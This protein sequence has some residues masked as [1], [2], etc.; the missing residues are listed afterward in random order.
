MANEIIHETNPAFYEPFLDDD[1][2]IMLCIGSYGSG[3]SFEMFH[4]VALKAITER[5]RICVIR[6]EY[7]RHKDSTFEDLSDAFESFGVIDQFDF[8]KSPLKIQH[9]SDRNRSRNKYSEIIFKD[10]SDQKKIKGIKNIDYM[11]VEEA[12]EIDYDILKELMGRLRTDSVRTHMLMMTNPGL[13][14]DSVDRIIKEW[15]INLEEL[16]EKKLLTKVISVDVPGKGKRDIKIKIHHST[17][18]DNLFNSAQFIQTIENYTDPDMIQIARLGRYGITEGKVFK[19]LEKMDNVWDWIKSVSGKTHHF[20]WYNGLDF[21]YSVSF[22]CLVKMA[23][24]RDSRTLYIY[25]GVYEKGLNTDT[26]IERLKNS[27]IRGEKLI[28]DNAEPR[29]IDDLNQAGLWVESAK[30]GQGSV[31]YGL[32]TLK[33]FRKI[34]I[35]SSLDKVWND[36][37]GLSRVKEKDGN[38]SEKR[39]NIDPH[40]LTGDTLVDTIYGAKPIKDLVG[41]EGFLA[42]YDVENKESTVS[43]YYDCKK[44]GTN[45]KIYKITT[46]DG[47]IIKATDYHPIL[48]E[49]GYVQVKNLLPT[50]RIIDIKECL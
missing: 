11:V 22:D 21:G 6:R 23:I 14:N 32:Q 33:G 7:T 4:K 24:H 36:F 13:F 2:D 44:T 38:Y 46:E 41:T 3:K 8:L 45:Q 27:T 35:D 28:G 34:V 20:E 19:N 16:Y 49:R 31:N 10:A 48:T 39:F 25:N 43:K 50:D 9:K 40:C 1:F 18:K 29:L 26:L 42:C 17:Y 15:G 30:K 37:D 47:R 5:R 12:N